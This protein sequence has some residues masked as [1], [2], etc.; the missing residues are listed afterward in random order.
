MTHFFVVI[1]MLSFSLSLYLFLLYLH[2]PT[3]THVIQIPLRYYVCVAF[4]CLL[5]LSLLLWEC[6]RQ[7]RWRRWRRWRRR[8]ATLQLLN[9][10][11]KKGDE[12]LPPHKRHK[13]G[14]IIDFKPVRFL[15]DRQ[16][17]LWWNGPAF[18]GLNGDLFVRFRLERSRM[19]ERQMEL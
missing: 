14:P 7:R 11:S 1:L 8:H 18:E 2:H 6:I 3:L 9:E 10:S 13:R 16:F 17:S 15:L 12:R 19:R 4:L 5:S